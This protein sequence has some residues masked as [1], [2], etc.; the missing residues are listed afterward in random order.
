M[1]Q[2]IYEKKLR[3]SLAYLAKVRKDLEESEKRYRHLFENAGDAIFVAD[4][5]GNF[6]NVNEKA[7]ELLGYTKDELLRMNVIDTYQP[8]T[9][10]DLIKNQI[11][12]LKKPASCFFIERKMCRKDSQILN[13]EIN[14]TIIS[15]KPVLI[16]AI[17]RN[18]TEVKRLK[19]KIEF[20]SEKR[21]KLTQNE[22]TI[23]YAIVKNPIIVDRKISEQYD[24]K[25]PT[26]T[27]IKNRLKKKKYVSCCSLPSPVLLDCKWLVITHCTLRG[28]VNNN[29]YKDRPSQIFFILSTKKDLIFSTMEKDI[30]RCNEA[31]NKFIDRLGR[32]K[33]IN[34]VESNYFPLNNN[35]ILAF[36]QFCSIANK[37]L[38]LNF[39][40][41]IFS[42]NLSP[43][44][45]ST[46]EKRILGAICEWPDA[47][48]VELTQK[49]QISR[50]KISSFKANL[51]NNKY[52]HLLGIPNFSK[53]DINLIAFNIIDYGKSISA[54]LRSEISAFSSAAFAFS[55]SNQIALLSF[56]SDFSDYKLGQ[57]QINK[58]LSSYS[59]SKEVILDM[60]NVIML[61]FDISRLVKNILR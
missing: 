44:S 12:L 27:A 41:D 58:V 55:N 37:A 31:V 40:D 59:K 23:L 38:S 11:E 29:L 57:E 14:L 4:D 51:I 35:S 15:K 10:S 25:R 21:I 20:L 48:D 32:S 2:K 36:M 34:S 18:I 60:D 39:N 46:K 9:Q 53:I 6:V 3:S 43:I 5:K 19:K 50:P 49:I 30:S 24:I 42:F 52:L 33:I 16:M 22:K 26:V 1:T 47:S 61:E 54:K 56:Y 13:V 8:K 17:V 7:I 45:L 28:D